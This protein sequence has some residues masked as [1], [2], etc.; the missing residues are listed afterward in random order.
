MCR[1]GMTGAAY[2]PSPTPRSFA[3]ASSIR[4]ATPDARVAKALGFLR[5]SCRPR[6]RSRRTRAEAEARR[7]ETEVREAVSNWAYHNMI[8]GSVGAIGAVGPVGA[9]C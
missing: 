2:R 8:V 5:T 4:S 3:S 7:K 9:A 6:R 1:L